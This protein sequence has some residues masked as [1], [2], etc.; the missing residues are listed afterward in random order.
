MKNITNYL[1]TVIK[2]DLIN[3][4]NYTNLK[5]IPKVKKV[6]LSLNCTT[7]ELKKLALMVLSIE[8]I[9][10]SQKSVLITA[11]KPSLLLKIKKGQPIGCSII[12]EKKLMYNFLFKLLV[13]VF[14]YLKKF[15][16]FPLN[17]KKNELNFCFNIKNL[18]DFKSLDTHFYLFNKLQ[19]LNVTIVTNTKTNEELIYLINSLKFITYFKKQ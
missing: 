15:K 19:N 7:T 4:F 6:V 2:Y 10:T 5:A 1:E 12:L 9:T 13:E 18:T 8:L 16:G 3:K 14:P 11:K 17:K